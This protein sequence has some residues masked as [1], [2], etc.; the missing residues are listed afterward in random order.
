MEAKN[1]F[2]SEGKA[3]GNENRRWHG[4]RR[5][6]NIGDKG[7]TS[8]CTDS[9]CSLCCILKTSFDLR[10]YKEATG[11]GRF[12]AGIYTSSAS[13][14]LVS[15]CSNEPSLNAR[16]NIAILLFRADS[17][18]KNE[19]NSKWKALLLNKVVVGR[20]LRMIQDDTT[21]TKPPPE[22]D[23]VSIL[24]FFFSFSGGVDQGLGHWDPRRISE[25]R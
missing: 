6:C 3:R 18:S 24:G 22:Y 2:A 20:D 4:T 7:S 12:G 14:K 8:F 1:N 16:S 11:W 10:H 25:L 19:S 15:I 23:S 21:L 5:T 13:S 9:K 17:Y